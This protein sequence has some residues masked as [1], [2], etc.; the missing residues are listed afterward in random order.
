[1]NKHD[2]STMFFKALFANKV[3]K[4]TCDLTDHLKMHR[5]YICKVPNFTGL[6]SRLQEVI[7]TSAEGFSF[8]KDPSV[9]MSFLQNPISYKINIY[10]ILRPC[11][12]QRNE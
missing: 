8:Q 4:S 5:C 3:H 7:A 6:L 9:S 11:L 1:M 2:L 10:T 12:V